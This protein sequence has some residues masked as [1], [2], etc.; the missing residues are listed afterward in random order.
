MKEDADRTNFD[1]VTARYSCSLT[2]VFETLKLQIQKDVEIR[3]KL[4]P[5]RADYVFKIITK[6]DIFTVFLE[7]NVTHWGVKF[8][9]S[10]KTVKTIEVRDENDKLMIEAT[11]TLNDD[12]ECRLQVNGQEREL[13][14]VRKMA[15]EKLFFSV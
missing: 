2:N 6:A 3:N 5:E 4:S 8:I 13:W 11:V 7:G 15:L 14:Q 1:W 12:G 10:S 9:L